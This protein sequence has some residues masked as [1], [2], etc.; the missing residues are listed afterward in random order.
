MERRLADERACRATSA[1]YRAGRSYVLW[2]L[3]DYFSIMRHESRSAGSLAQRSPEPVQKQTRHFSSESL[4]LH[5]LRDLPIF[6]QWQV[7]E[8]LSGCEKC[9]NRLHRVTE[10]V[11]AFRTEIC[12]PSW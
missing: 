8:H 10:V 7:E 11:A 5:A 9:R 1:I 4:G 6:Q 12:A 3:A 2:R